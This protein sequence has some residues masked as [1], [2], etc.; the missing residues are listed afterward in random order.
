[1]FTQAVQ[2]ETIPSGELFTQTITSDDPHSGECATMASLE[3]KTVTLV[4]RNSLEVH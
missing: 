3:A 4:K 1:M 2:S